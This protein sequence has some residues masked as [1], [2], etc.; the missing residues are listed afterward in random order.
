MRFE[1]TALQAFSFK[2]CY[3]QWNSPADAQDTAPPSRSGS[4][5]AVVARREQLDQLRP[6]SRELKVLAGR[7][8]L[9]GRNETVLCK[10]TKIVV[11]KPFVCRLVKGTVDKNLT[12]SRC[13]EF[14]RFRPS[15]QAQKPQR[16]IRQSQIRRNR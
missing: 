13:C 1:A 3:G 12:F 16:L 9:T 6:A 11:D 15:E 5:L 2:K 10:R 4:T 14:R 7:R 8:S